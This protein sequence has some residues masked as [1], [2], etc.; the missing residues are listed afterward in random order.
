MRK[1]L[2]FG[3][4]M[5]TCGTSA[6]RWISVRVPKVKRVDFPL[7]FRNQ[8]NEVCLPSGGNPLTFRLKGFV[9]RS[10]VQQPIHEFGNF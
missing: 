4:G 7:G 8:E 9:L 5:R 3:Q 2:D 1:D 6:V 10:T